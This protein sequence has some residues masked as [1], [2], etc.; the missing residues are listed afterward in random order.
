MEENNH[1]EKDF[2]EKYLESYRQEQSDPTNESHQFD[3]AVTADGS[4]N[5]PAASAETPSGTT[6]SFITS[7]VQ[8][9]GHPVIDFTNA[10]LPKG[11]PV[12]SRHKA[13]IK[14]AYDLLIIC[15]G[16][17]KKVL[18]L[19]MQLQW[20]KDIVT[21]RG[22]KE[23]D[24]IMDAAQKLK[25]KRESENYYELQPSREMKRAIEQVTGRK[26][27]VLVWEARRQMM[28]ATGGEGAQD[29]VTVMLERIGR[30]I[31][32]LFPRYPLL[33][34]LCHRLERKYYVVALFVGGAYAMTL[35]TR[36]W[37]RPCSCRSMRVNRQPG[38]KPARP[39]K[40]CASRASRMATMP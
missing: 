34:L 6:T 40:P 18:N 37:W 38:R 39:L 31:E 1:F 13:A 32:K 7:E 19:L 30:E 25:H 11:A 20:V 2:N 22:Q 9:Y 17:A 35:M 3:T 14:L 36:C 28:G 4:V 21:E 27:T 29:S 26:Y 8:A 12:G 15:D 10:M 33:K 16:A 24:D 5:N 23:I